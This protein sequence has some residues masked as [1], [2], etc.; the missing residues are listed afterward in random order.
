MKK[1]Q[2]ILLISLSL[3]SMLTSALEIKHDIN[4]L[5]TGFYGILYQDLQMKACGG[6]FSSKTQNV[7]YDVPSSVKGFKSV[8][9]MIKN[10]IIKFQAENTQGICNLTFRTDL[11]TKAN[12]KVV[13]HVNLNADR[14][15]AG[16]TIVLPNEEFCS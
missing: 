2:S 3:L 9:N 1:L 8:D 11:I 15:S 14:I 13:C 5:D 10:S 6:I 16:E 4:Q 7:Y 12:T